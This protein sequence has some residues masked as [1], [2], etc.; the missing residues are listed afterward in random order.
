M[1]E[2]LS[3]KEEVSLLVKKIPSRL[4][5]LRPALEKSYQSPLV[6]NNYS[7]SPNGLLTQKP[8]GREE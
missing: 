1:D 2:T 3:W 5:L 6:F 7:S 8:W 4:A